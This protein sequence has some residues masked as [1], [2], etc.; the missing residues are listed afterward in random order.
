MTD[1]V[2]I[3]TTSNADLQTL[4]TGGQSAVSAW[5]Q[6]TNHL[7]RSLGEAHAD[8]LAEPNPDPD[9]GTTDWYG[10]RI[11]ACVA[12]LDLPEPQQS[13]SRAKL[14][15]LLGD[16]R[17]ESDKL[18]QSAQ[19]S[20]RYLGEMLALA[21]SVPN[22]RSVLVIDSAPVLVG[23]GHAPAGGAAR[24]ELLVGMTTVRAPGVRVAGQAPMRIVGP[25][26]PP[27]P[28]RSW[29]PAAW[30]TLSLPLLLLLLL[31]LDP[32][33]WFVSQPI[34]CELDPR[35]TP[36]LTEMR[37]GQEEESRLRAELARLNVALGDLRTRCAPIPAPLRPALTAPRPA[38][39]LDPR[40][41]PKLTPGEPP[42]MPIAPESSQPQQ[43]LDLDRARER[44]GQSGRLQIVLAWDDQNDLDL[45]VRCPSGEIISFRQRSACGGTLDVDANYEPP[46]TTSPVE[47]VVFPQPPVPGRYVLGVQGALRHT[48]AGPSSPFRLMV[49]TEGEPDRVLNG[50]VEI[51]QTVQT[52]LDL[53]ARP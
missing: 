50:T 1:G 19:P 38:A 12:L 23:W 18:K 3:A 33:S 35:S 28:A 51:G 27:L 32:M 41:L 36:L 52:S 49:R 4:G 53:P 11:G 31:W 25:P 30:A 43:R 47:S 24:P 21:L 45:T 15:R 42:A 48:P 29:A 40:P 39:V 37:A 6:I 13:T 46:F 2:L 10:P 14:A 7:R 17:A 34:V 22:D 44:G 20:S 16:I 26:P 8:L 9:R 5:G